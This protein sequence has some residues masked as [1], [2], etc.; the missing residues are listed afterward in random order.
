M[1]IFSRQVSGVFSLSTCLYDA[2]SGVISPRASF[3]C[4][5]IA[6]ERH[7]LCAFIFSVYFIIQICCGVLSGKSRARKMEKRPMDAGRGSRGPYPC[8]RRNV[9]GRRSLARFKIVKNPNNHANGRNLLNFSRT[10]SH[11]TPIWVIIA[12]T[13]EYVLLHA[14]TQLEICLSASC[15]DFLHT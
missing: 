7:S 14:L 13:C 1:G 8:R 15:H 2:F 6:S 4:V 9:N 10:P 5:E 12:Y 11:V 3:F